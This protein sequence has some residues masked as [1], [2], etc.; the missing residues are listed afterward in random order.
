MAPSK[1]T[2]VYYISS[3]GYGHAARASQVIAA[4]PPEV[5]VIVRT[6]V[7][8]AFIQRESGRKL[9]VVPGQF[10]TGVLQKDNRTL[11]WKSTFR[12]AQR[13]RKECARNLLDEVEFLRKNRADIIVCDVP[14]APLE[15]ARMAGIPSVVVGN[16]TWTDIFAREGKSQPEA[17]EL[18][19]YWRDQYAMATLAIRTPP[20]FPMSYFPRVKTVQ[21]IARR[22]RNIRASLLRFLGKPRSERLVLLYFG[23]FGDS[24]LQVPQMPGVTFLAMTKMPAP[25]V[26]I[27]PSQWHF[28]DVVASADCVI[29]KPGY[30]TT[31]E[32]MANGTPLIYHPRTEFAEYPIL[33]RAIIEWGGGAQIPLRQFE[34]GQWKNALAKAFEL[35]PRQVKSHGAAQTATAILD[36][37][38]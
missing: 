34:S 12:L 18:A 32:C 15:A 1:P 37:I 4:L 29:A 38:I 5:R 31:G 36:L 10:D 35:K 20:A 13:V 23:T 3:H 28:P 21:P 22:G 11:D 17:A 27:D 2:I 9:R 14:P 19:E 25:A 26:E 7:D 24:G 8:P 33:R 6:M 16:F 30:G